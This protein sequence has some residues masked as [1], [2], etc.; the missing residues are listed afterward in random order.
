MDSFLQFFEQMPSWQK[1]VWVGICLSV[2]WVLEGSYP[3]LKLNYRKW[4]HA[5]VNMVFMA[6]S[7]SISILFAATT[8]G[9]VE[10]VR[11]HEFGL[12]FLVDWPVFIELVVTVVLLDFVAQYFAHFLLHKVGLLWRVHMVHHSDTHVDATTGTRL[13]PGDFLVREAFALVA[14]VIAGAPISFYL[15]YRFLTIFFTYLTHANLALPPSL[16]RAISWVFVTPNMHKFHHHFE[17]PWTDSN[18]GGILSIWDRMF[19]TFVYDDPLKIRY[20][21]DVLSDETDE[22]VLYQLK[23]PFD[24][25]IKR[26][27]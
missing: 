4:R 19:G 8:V 9:V 1:L 6:T 10:W 20:G 7:L 2:S 15:V 3:L 18:Y 26:G 11:N 22:D 5:G 17:M 24:G 16:D 14:I 21:L 12:L 23:M 27:R 25:D 13:H